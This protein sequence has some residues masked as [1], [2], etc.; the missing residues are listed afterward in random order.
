MLRWPDCLTK[1]SRS[2]EKSE[3]CAADAAAFELDD[4]DV[5]IQGSL[6]GRETGK[7]GMW[8][9]PTAPNGRRCV[10]SVIAISECLDEVEET[11]EEEWDGQMR[12]EADLTERALVDPCRTRRVGNGRDVSVVDELGLGV[13]GVHGVLGFQLGKF[14]C[15]SSSTEKKTRADLFWAREA[16]PEMKCV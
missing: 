4:G 1:A 16:G 2:S 13:L 15:R 11:D 9:K 8:S 6:K 14:V 3:E 12:G 7:D 10:S 5:A